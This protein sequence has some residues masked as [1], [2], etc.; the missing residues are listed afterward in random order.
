MIIIASFALI[1]NY[2]LLL[3]FFLQNEETAT[4]QSRLIDVQ[5]LLSVQQEAS[6]SKVFDLVKGCTEHTLRPLKTIDRALMLSIRCF[7]LRG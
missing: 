4:L 1:K 6:N 7:L 2:H 5:Q 3:R